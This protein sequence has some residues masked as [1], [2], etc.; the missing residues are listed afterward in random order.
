MSDTAHQNTLIATM[1]NEGSS[2]ADIARRL[3]EIHGI[4]ITPRTVRY[5]ISKLKEQ[6]SLDYTENDDNESDILKEIERES[7]S[8]FDIGILDIETTGLWADFG[9]VLCAVI[10][11]LSEDGKD[12]FKVFR[13]D[14]T[15]SYNNPENRAKPEFWRRIDKE[16][17]KQ[18]YD[19][20]STY[21]IVVH[22]NGRSFDIKFI[23]TRMVKNEIPILPEMKQLD[24]YQIARH[25]LRLRS[26]RLDALKEFL[27][28][29]TEE[30]G[31]KWEYWQMAANGQKAGF[32]FVVDHCKRDV[33]RLAQVA[34]RMKAQINYIKK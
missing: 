28:I 1:Y 16:L 14:E 27:E 25:R 21:D 20:Y 23:N 32:D 31:H 10:L 15:E 4:N 34:R 18:V 12:K 11:N 19:E 13:L 7:G 29:D 24:I 3:E 30:S 8:L 6:G 5:R 17:L 33:A 9:Y 26:K 2:S 22:F